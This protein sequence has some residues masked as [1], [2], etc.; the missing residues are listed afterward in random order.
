MPKIFL[1]KADSL[2]QVRFFDREFFC[3]HLQISKRLMNEN[4]RER[5]EREREREK[6]RETERHRVMSICVGLFVCM[7]AREYLAAVVRDR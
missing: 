4:L 1:G 6:E 7:L 5:F 3:L 2:D